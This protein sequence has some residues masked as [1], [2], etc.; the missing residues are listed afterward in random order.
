MRATL[1]LT[2]THAAVLTVMCASPGHAECLP[3]FEEISE[4]CCVATVADLQSHLIKLR[5]EKIASQ[6]DNERLVS[7]LVECRSSIKQ[8]L[9]WRGYYRNNPSTTQIR[10]CPQFIG[11]CGGNVTGEYCATGESALCAT[12]EPGYFMKSWKTCERSESPEKWVHVALSFSLIATLVAVAVKSPE[13]WVHVSVELHL[14]VHRKKFVTLWE[15]IW[16]SMA[17]QVKIIGSTLQIFAQF[18]VLLA[19][20]MPAILSDFYGGALD[21]ESWSCSA[22]RGAR[23]VRRGYPAGDLRGG[24]PYCWKANCL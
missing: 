18:S 9:V 16:T 7:D 21:S 17:N 6:K 20:H 1:L 15:F 23:A 2:V 24:G 8:P 5:T 22:L 19:F 14:V 4:D 11:C 13:T 10:E 3:S 12:C